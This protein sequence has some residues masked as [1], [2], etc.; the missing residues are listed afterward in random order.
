MAEPDKTEA[1]T[2]KRLSDARKKGNVPRSTDVTTAIILGTALLYVRFRWES[3]GQSLSSLIAESLGSLPNHDLSPHSV[4]DLLLRDGAVLLAVAGP[5]CLTLLVVGLLVNIAQVGPMFTTETMRP[6]LGKLNPLTGF[7]RFFSAH[8]FVDLGKNLLKIAI[9]V[10]IIWG[11]LVQRYPM[12][13]SGW[14]MGPAKLA[15]LLADT[16]WQMVTRLL[17]ALVS[18]AVADFAWQRFD[19]RRSLRMSKQE[20]KDELK[21]QEGSPEVKGEIRKRMRQA[22]RRRM[23][24][25]VPKATVVIT[26]PTHFAVA[27]LY[28]RE[29]MPTPMVVA[30]GQDFVALRIRAIAEEHDVPIVENPPVARELYRVAEIGNIIPPVLYQAIAEILV[31]L[32]KVDPKKV[33]I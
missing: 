6:N 12:I 11:L 16:A 10:S 29:T 5:F 25:Q 26:N 22:A 27:L 7:K 21:Q 32:Q 9:L 19:Y 23:M 20:I 2:P 4:G 18:I 3:M 33:H 8:V 30:K 15:P 28:D 14:R 31:T 1:P 24:Q 13:V 17:M